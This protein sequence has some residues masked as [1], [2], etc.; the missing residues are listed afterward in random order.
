MIWILVIISAAAVAAA[1]EK[2]CPVLEKPN[3]CRC[4]GS[5]DRTIRCVNMIVVPRFTFTTEV[6][7]KLDLSDKSNDITMLGNLAF[8]RLRVREIDLTGN[9][10]RSIDLH[11]FSR[12]HKDYLQ[13]IK[14]KGNTNLEPPLIQMQNL[15]LLKEMHLEGFFMPTINQNT[16]F[17]FF[18]NLVHLE[19]MNHKDDVCLVKIVY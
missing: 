17:D 3:K 11:A 2:D 10:L 15:T 8:G 12:E 19:T 7:A 6:F 9:S 5:E 4:F 13:V 16:R 18:P 14:L 1:A